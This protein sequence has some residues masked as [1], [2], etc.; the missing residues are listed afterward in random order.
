MPLWI[1][2]IGSVL[3]AWFV[4]LVASFGHHRRAV[5]RVAIRREGQTAVLAHRGAPLMWFHVASLG[6]LEQAIPV[7]QAFRAAHPATPW[8]LTVY[9][10]SA[11]HPLQAKGLPNAIPGWREGDLA[12]VL[13]DDHPGTWRTWLDTVPFRALALAK[14]D[15]WPNLLAACRARNL[16]VHAF[17]AAPSSTRSNPTPSTPALWRL[18]SSI[19]VQDAAAAKSFA[20]IGLTDHV[21]VDGDPRVERVLS[22]PASPL[23]AWTDWAASASQVVVAG[24]TWPEEERAL[25]TL[26]WHPDRRLVLV[27]HD[28]S[29][30]HLAALD[31]QWEGGA[32]RATQWQVL[33]PEARNRWS[34]V[35]VDSTGMLFDLYCIGTVAVVGGGHGTGLHNVLEPASAGLPIVTGPN[36]GAFRE[37]HALQDLGA[38]TSGDVADLTHA[39]LADAASCRQFGAAGLA[40]LQSQQGASARIVQRWS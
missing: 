24:S 33:E 8:L 21:T 2:R 26:D 15:L 19:S 14:Y 40:W 5:A 22:R 6:E 34:V 31:R 30:A 20:R 35:I 29:S 17:A 1:L 11:W 36:L 3:W 39:W 38:L 28:L 27:P 12:A 37:A 16:T 9:S 32:I 23:Q 7:M 13:P 18:L 4:R 25:R 10:P